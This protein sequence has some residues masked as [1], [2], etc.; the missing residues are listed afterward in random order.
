MKPGVL[1]GVLCALGAGGYFGYEWWQEKKAKEKLE[2]EKAAAALNAD[3]LDAGVAAQ[4]PI[5]VP[6]LSGLT[7]EEAKAKLSKLGFKLD[8]FKVLDDHACSYA[9]EKDMRPKGHICGQD[10][11]AGS[12]S[13]A[14]RKIEVTIEVDS[15]EAGG[16]GT[17]GEWKRM[18][19]LV[20]MSLDAA[21]SKLRG[22]GFGEEEFQVDKEQGCGPV[23]LICETEPAGL[24]R[25][26]LGRL[27]TLTVAE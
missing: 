25:K 12:H 1:L 15:Y 9:Q 7:V 19:E 21:K 6:D 18:P 5:E 10:P 24:G 11:P 22:L 3:N 17:P 27:G 16:A 13:A 2:K 26:V 23:G 20:G 8:K 4:G 14:T